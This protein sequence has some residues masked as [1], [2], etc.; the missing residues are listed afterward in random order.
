MERINKIRRHNQQRQFK[1]QVRD[2]IIKQFEDQNIEV[3]SQI[4][5]RDLDGLFLGAGFE[6]TKV[7]QNELFLLMEAG[8][9]FNYDKLRKWAYTNAN[10]LIKSDGKVRQISI[11]PPRAQFRSKTF[12]AE[13][14]LIDSPHKRVNPYENLKLSPQA[15]K[16]YMSPAKLVTGE[17]LKF[18]AKMLQS[19]LSK[20]TMKILRKQEDH[21][22]EDEER[23]D[24]QLA[25]KLVSFPQPI[26]EEFKSFQQLNKKKQQLNKTQDDIQSKND[27]ISQK[28]RNLRKTFMRTTKL[29]FN[30]GEANLDSII[31]DQPQKE[32]KQRKQ[33][34][35]NLLNVTYTH[36][37]QDS[38]KSELK[39]NQKNY[40]NSDNEQ[41]S[42]QMKVQILSKNLR[43][44]FYD[45]MN[46]TFFTETNTNQV[47][48]EDDYGAKISQLNITNQ[49]K[50]LKNQLN[51]QFQDYQPAK[52]KEQK[53]DLD[54][55]RR[56]ERMNN[57]R[58]KSERY[59]QERSKVLQVQNRVKDIAQQNRE[60]NQ[61]IQFQRNQINQVLDVIQKNQSAE[62]LLKEAFE[63]VNLNNILAD[64][65]KV[66][67]YQTQVID[68]L[69]T[70]KSKKERDIEANVQYMASLQPT[71]IG[72]HR[73]TKVMRKDK[74]FESQNGYKIV[75]KIQ[76]HKDKERV[77]YLLNFDLSRN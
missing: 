40:E 28:Q 4:S 29:N 19:N 64:K 27:Q 76:T 25:N 15:Q 24:R 30:L 46:Q 69:R 33:S 50:L 22:D 70:S 13:K 77:E 56:N 38:L 43:K 39:I 51:N 62:I 12:K 45:T 3:D 61:K 54:Q 72:M 58:L 42:Q 35:G 66:K 5:L 49:L 44:T 32:A 34:L 23:N 47:D 68:R 74:V 60:H 17:K 37:K 55:N 36:M 10:F 65:S 59:L 31:E 14:S 75:S 21:F 67:D 73:F 8:R 52:K 11:S 16:R 18:T 7:Q 71:A 48:H 1:K 6:L 63:K 53:G 20:W 2:S 41:E 9:K 57:I 26:Y